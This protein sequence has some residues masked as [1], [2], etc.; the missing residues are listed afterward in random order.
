M[1]NSS[2]VIQGNQN[3]TLLVQWLK[4]QYTQ[5]P[6]LSKKQERELIDKYKNDR[7]QLNE[8]LF[9][10]NIRIVYNIAKRYKNKTEDFDNMIQNGMVG[11]MEAAK[12]FDINKDIKFVTYAYAW[13]SKY[14]LSE[15]YQKNKE[16]LDNS[17]SLSQTISN[18]KI[19]DDD[20]DFEDCVNLFID[21][22][23]VKN[24]NIQ[25]ELSSHEQEH[26]VAKLMDSMKKDNSLSSTDKNVFIDI[27]Y[28][29]RKPSDIANKYDLTIK[30]VNSIKRKILYRFK[31]E[32]QTTYNI[33]QYSDLS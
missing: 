16:V 23:V 12:R 19:K 5:Y 18:N 2:G 7:N 8:L 20:S 11:L 31:T 13:V 6:I 22:S 32:L 30:D 9:M 1:K 14:I 24:K 15:F 10:Y 33:M 4:K 21:P 29:H 25:D 28:N 3:A 17:N 27:F 26:L